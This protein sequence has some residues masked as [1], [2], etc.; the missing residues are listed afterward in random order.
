ME[1]LSVKLEEVGDRLDRVS[2]QQELNGQQ[3]ASNAAGI[4]ELRNLVA[5]LVR[6]QG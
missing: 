1:R 5:D 6:G 2:L 3:I 4:V